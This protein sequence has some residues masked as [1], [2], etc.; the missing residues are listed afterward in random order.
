M[1]NNFVFESKSLL[2]VEGK[3]ECN[4]F[5]ALLGHLDIQ[6]IQLLDIGGKDKFP[7]EFLALYNAEGFNK[8]ERLGFVRDAET[9]K[10]Q[11]AFNS[12]CNILKKTHLP[13]PSQ[14]GIVT[15]NKIPRIGIFIMP[16]NTGSGML[17]NLCLETLKTLPVNFCIKNFVDCFL[18]QQSKE[19][20]QNFND[21]KARVQAYLS[22]RS[23]IVNTLGL[24][25]I[26]GYWDFSHFCFDNIKNFLTSLY[27]NK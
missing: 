27:M 20:K 21:F 19:E 22:T 9:N 8:I 4:F 10:A 23:P 26:K 18:Q 15:I 17:E 25:A 3:D 5:K 14:M 7:F 6:D 1:R 24:G 2:L 11:S 13:L 16:D 12:I